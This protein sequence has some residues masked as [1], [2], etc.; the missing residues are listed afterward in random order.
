MQGQKRNPLGSWAGRGKG[1]GGTFK[2]AVFGDGQPG[3]G[4]GAG[5]DERGE[6]RAGQWVLRAIESPYPASLWLLHR[7]G[8][9]D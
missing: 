8:H 9:L 5:G 6:G 7:Q 4:R 3:G 1:M 2:Q